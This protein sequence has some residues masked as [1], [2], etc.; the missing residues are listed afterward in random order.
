MRTKSLFIIVGLAIAGL[1][2]TLQA[3][4]M[5]ASLAPADAEDA[6]A[7]AMLAQFPVIADFEGGVPTGWFVY[8]DWGNIAITITVPTISD[9]DGLALPGQVGNNDILSVTADIPTWAGF[10]A[11]F[12]PIQD[13][14]DYDA[15][16]F[17]F[18]GENSGALHEFEIQTV[19]GDDR[20][21]TF[22]DSFT[23]WRQII[24]PFHT[25]G[26][27]GAYDVSQ[28]DNWV[29]VLD[30]TIGSFKLDHLEL[31]NLTPFADFEGGV[32]TGWFVYGDWGNI[33]ITITVPTISDTDGLALPGQVG[34]NDILSVT[35]DIPTWAGFGAGFTP[36]QD[37]SDMQGV[38]FWFYGESSGALHEFEIQTASGDDRRAT[39]TEDFTGWRLI[40]LPF[41]TFGATPYDVSQVDNWVFVLDGTIGAFKIDQIGTY[42]DAGNAPLKVQ[43]D[44]AAYS[45]L[46]GSVITLT[47][48]LSAVSS[49]TVSVDY[50][51]AD[52]TATTADYVPIAGTLTFAPGETSKQLLLTT[53]DDADAEDD[54][55]VNVAL[56]NPVSVTLGVV[57]N[58]VVTIV[59]DEQPNVGPLTVVDDYELTQLPSGMD[60]TATI[61][62]LTFNAPA[63]AAAITLTQV[64]TGATPPPVPGLGTPNT[65]LQLDTTVG[66]GEWAGF[67][68]AFADAGVTTWTPQDW[69]AF[70]GVAF[71]LYGNDTGATLF[72]DI[73]DN[74]NPGSSSDDAERWSIDIPDTFSGWQFFAIPFADFNRKDIGNG[75]PNDGLT[76]TEMHGYAFGVFGSV[77]AGAQTNYVEQFAL[78]GSSNQPLQV[79]FTAA[80]YSVVEGS[81]AVL[82][83]SLNMT[84]SQPVTVTYATAESTAIP[85]RDFTP[86]GGTLVFA[87]GET[88]KTLTV[89]TLDDIKHEPDEKVVVVLSNPAGADLGF[90][91]RTVVLLTDDDPTDPNLLHDFEGSHPFQVSG[92]AALT[93]TE[94]MAGSPLALPTQGLYENVLTV[95]YDTAAGPASLETTF[96]ESQDWRGHEAL[97]FWYYGSGSGDT[98]TVTLLDNQLTTTADVPPADWTLVWSDEFDDP[99]GSPPNPNVWQHEL[100]DGTLNGIPGWGNS[101]SQ[102]YTNSLDN[103]ATDGSGNLVI[104]VRQVNTATT[105]LVCWY[106]PCEYTSARLISKERLAFEYGRIEA[107]IQVPPGGPGLWPAFWMLGTDIDQVGWPQTGE[108]DIMEYVSRIPTEIFGT[109]HGPGYSGGNAFG[110][111]YDFGA[112]V[113]QSYHTIAVE[114]GPD[115]IHWFVDG[116]NFHNAVP[117]DV[118]PNEWVYNHPFF[119]L[120]NV[121][122]GGNFGGS[123]DP[124]ISFPQ[125]MLVDYV[126]VYQAD[127][128]SE[129]FEA[130]FVD[131]FTGWRKIML[132]FADFSR[133][134]TQPPGAPADGLTL[135]EVWGYGITLPAGSSGLVHLDQVR[136][137][138][139]V[140]RLYLPILMQQP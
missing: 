84:S 4:A 102:Y 110:N 120:L 140:P 33:G 62:W 125:S 95:D 7:N 116:I 47:V 127:N 64:Q 73:L 94:I 20:R 53:L 113:S 100:G 133:A 24:L 61:G 42:G 43:F 139:Q 13:W 17:W 50:A 48:S 79:A 97:S 82:T 57:A 75:A 49:D 138:T 121:A 117:A 60:G 10:G 129:R 41:A 67:T 96:V 130:T 14:S 114:W 30:G 115:E 111:T 74:R 11:G 80:E 104:S 56:S 44:A 126:R 86:T 28:V 22:T 29:F 68:H 12:T 108:I 71:W 5:P 103:A 1:L 59:D 38:S 77:N 72:V 122:I 101:E 76:L 54:E 58:A 18:Y 137:E 36:V 21:A 69:S 51:S 89:A 26:A 135:A 107:R 106:G 99:A 9:T 55:T 87:P 81:T 23:G 105:N 85:G 63:A 118:A 131:D 65:V 31:V 119:L 109:I 19:P 2:F 128:T 124:N 39:F 6:Q 66:P 112:P 32:P 34:N 132:P 27:G 134:A 3:L 52:G 8:G 90:R 16:S 46:E 45:G 98:V 37:W 123:I 93:I 83:A 92:G 35:A 91:L 70:E 78:Y 88:T 136:L 40:S 15:I 25:F